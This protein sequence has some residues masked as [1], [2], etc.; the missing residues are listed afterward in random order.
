MAFESALPPPAV[1]WW[2]ELLFPAPPIGTVLPSAALG[3]ADYIVKPAYKAGATSLSAGTT[4][5]GGV[6][7]GYTNRNGRLAARALSTGANWFESWAFPWW[8]FHGDNVAELTPGYQ[9]DDASRVAW[10]RVG[11]TQSAIDA[12][13]GEGT[14]FFFLPY[15]GALLSADFLPTG[16]SFPGGFGICGDG[17]GGWR[18]RSWNAAGVALETVDIAPGIIGTL[19][20]WHLFDF[21]LRASTPASL[22][23]LTVKVNGQDILTEREFDNVL[24]I[25]PAT[26]NAQ[27]STLAFAQGGHDPGTGTVLYWWMHARFGRFLPDGTE[28]Q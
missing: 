4:G 1:D 13:W 21:V 17:A 16:V 3:T 5:G 14:G 18:Y 11:V 15:T 22:G 27:A 10:F 28:V 23:W 12:T 20:D 26:L 19:T 24:L 25:P 9:E 7:K 2:A 8:A 6:T